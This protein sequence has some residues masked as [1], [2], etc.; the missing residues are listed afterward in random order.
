MYFVHSYCVYPAASASWLAATDYG[1]DR[2]C[3]VLADGNL[4]GC[5]FHPERSGEQGLK[6]LKNFIGLPSRVKIAV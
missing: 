6:I 5:Q 2:F 3:S 4:W 1:R